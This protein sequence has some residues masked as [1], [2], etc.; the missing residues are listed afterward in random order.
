MPSFRQLGRRDHVERLVIQKPLRMSFRILVAFV[1][2]G[3]RKEV[4]FIRLSILH[5]AFI[6]SFVKGSPDIA[7][8]LDLDFWTDR[9]KVKMRDSDWA[10]ERRSRCRS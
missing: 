6:V 10:N 5:I 1:I 2:L 8:V 7:N 9:T 4:V 3:R